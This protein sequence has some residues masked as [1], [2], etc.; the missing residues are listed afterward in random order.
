M[1]PHEKLMAGPLGRLV[2][3][4]TCRDVPNLSS[5]SLACVQ[6]TK[7]GTPAQ[8]ILAP[9]MQVIVETAGWT[10]KKRKPDNQRIPLLMVSANTALHVR[11]KRL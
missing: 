8:V 1:L 10:N 9:I 7:N 4:M 11:Q 6:G 2:T 3:V 5:S